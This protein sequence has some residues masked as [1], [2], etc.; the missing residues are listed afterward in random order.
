MTR[1]RGSESSQPRRG[2][3]S[4]A[5][6]LALAL[7][8]P[9]LGAVP[10]AEETVR[11]AFTP[12]RDPTELQGSAREFAEVFGRLTGYAVRP[13]VAADYAGVVEALRA[14]HVEMAFVHSVGYV[15]ASREAGCRILAKALRRGAATYTARIYVRRDSGLRALEDLRG[16][17]I[18]FVD[19]TSTSGYIYPMAMLIRAGLVRDRDP[20][21][22]FREAVFAGGHD[23]ALTALLHGAVDAAAV[24]DEAP[25]RFVRD[26]S[27]LAELLMIAESPRIPNDGV[28]ARPGLPPEM[29]ARLTRGL[30]AMNAPAH[31]PVLQR[32][33]AID[34]LEPAEDGDYD[35][36]REAVN[37]LAIPR[38]RR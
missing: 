2:A 14:R 21:T 35:P 6:L 30:L 4:L 19:P 37:L 8:A 3:S 28:C 5:G 26:P 15:Y 32:L 16:R 12:S 33:Y 7:L 38:P 9:G 29:L 25:Q 31:R 13:L 36:V 34:G 23:A 11:V 22:F 18:A 24:F 1:T 10:A 20:R 17:R 27:R